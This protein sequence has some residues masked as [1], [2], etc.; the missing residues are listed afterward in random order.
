MA[1]VVAQDILASSSIVAQDIL[2]SSSSEDD[3]V[4]EYLRR[5]WAKS[6]GA[7]KKATV[8]SNR[9]RQ[10]MQAGGG[11]A[12]ARPRARIPGPHAFVEG[13]SEEER[14]G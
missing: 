9:E 2:A 14:V 8:L 13:S 10:V 6:R 4:I 5:D 12:R 3:D 1:E 11:P 7:R